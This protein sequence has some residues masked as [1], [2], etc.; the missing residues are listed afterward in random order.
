M[1]IF[2]NDLVHK[3]YVWTIYNHLF[4]VNEC[5]TKLMNGL[6]TFLFMVDLIQS[7][8]KAKNDNANKHF[9]TP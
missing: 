4:N 9:S 8:T 1:V 2:Q 3:K 7:F 5:N 6:Y